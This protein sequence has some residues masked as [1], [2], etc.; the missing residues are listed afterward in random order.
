MKNVNQGCVNNEI[1]IYDRERLEIKSHLSRD[2]NMIGCRIS[3]RSYWDT[4][5]ESCRLKIER[6]PRGESAMRR[7]RNMPLVVSF[8]DVEAV[9][10][11]S[12]C[13]LTWGRLA[14][15]IMWLHRHDSAYAWWYRLAQHHCQFLT[16]GLVQVA[17]S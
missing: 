16:E 11:E 13:N 7:V 4:L 2:T 6:H 10:F 17:T 5:V 15:F 1:C 12:R 14:V 8:E 9:M 3:C